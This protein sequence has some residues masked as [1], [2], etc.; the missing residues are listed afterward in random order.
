MEKK[1]SIMNIRCVAFGLMHSEDENIRI[2]GY[3]LEDRIKN[4]DE[5]EISKVRVYT[6]GGIKGILDMLF[7]QRV[8]PAS[9]Y[10]DSIHEIQ[11][12]IEY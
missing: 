6:L 2:I 7:L 10:T 8:L 1:P 9:V 5:A 3:I 11:N 12:A 4:Y